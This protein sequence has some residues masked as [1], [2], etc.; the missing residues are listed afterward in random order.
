M[1]IVYPRKY[2]MK[3]YFVRHAERDTGGDYHNPLLGHQDNP[4]TERGLTQARRLPAAFAGKEFSS[5]RVS[6]YLRTAKTAERLAADR[7]MVPVV[8]ARLNEIDNG[9]IEGLTPEEIQDAF[10]DFWKEYSARTSD[11]RFPGG[12]TGAEVKA[13]QD[14]LLKELV[15]KGEDAVLVCHE[16]FIRLLLCNVL[17]MPVYL[18]H[19]FKIDF[20]S[21][22]EL[23]YDRDRGEF[24]VLGVNLPLPEV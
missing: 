18:R 7:G 9:R 15:D 17:G 4:L 1:W 20:C 5:I 13:R 3:L 21:M 16:G 24:R 2:Y 6:A 10:P 19:K 14:A 8:D 23:E 22:T 12:E 11:C